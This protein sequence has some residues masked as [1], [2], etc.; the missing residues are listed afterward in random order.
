MIA[1][2]VSPAGLIDQWRE[3]GYRDHRRLHENLRVLTERCQLKQPFAITV[4][5]TLRMK[6]R[7]YRDQEITWKHLAASCALP[8]V[9]PQV[10]LDGRW[11]SD[12]GLLQSLPI[13]AALELGAT[14]IIGLNVLTKY[15]S[16]ALASV[17]RVFRA[18]FAPRSVVPPHVK[19][20]ERGPSKMLGGLK[21]TLKGTQTEVQSWIDLGVE[22][23]RA[24]L[25]E[26]PFPL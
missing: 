21:S 19:I 17:V 1:S 26:K 15:P 25:E 14:E 9:L 5:E 22:D 4:T 8:V 18:T 13:S 6:P 10:R 20:A 23:A 16:Q 2:G 12:G 11:L 24:W 7:I 3:A